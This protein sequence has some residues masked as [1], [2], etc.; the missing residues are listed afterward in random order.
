MLLIVSALHLLDV[1]VLWFESYI[2]TIISSECTLMVPSVYVFPQRFE[3]CVVAPIASP[4]SF[5]AIYC[6]LLPVRQQLI[7]PFSQKQEGLSR[8]PLEEGMAIASFSMSPHYQ[9]Q[10]AFLPKALSNVVWENYLT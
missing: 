8:Y 5:N 3:L 10:H 6:H 1:I 4:S 9:S 2:H 7:D